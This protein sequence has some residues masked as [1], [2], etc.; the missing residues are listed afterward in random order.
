MVNNE[1]FSTHTK[2][3]VDECKE[4]YKHITTTIHQK[5]K[6]TYHLKPSCLD[7]ILQFPKSDMEDN[8]DYKSM[9]TFLSWHTEEDYQEALMDLSPKEVKDI[10]NL[11]KNASMMIFSAKQ[12]V[13]SIAKQ[14]SE[15]MDMEVNGGRTPDD[16]RNIQKGRIE[17]MEEALKTITDEREASIMMKYINDIGQT[18]NFSFMTSRLESLEDKEIKNI[19]AGFF[20]EKKGK[21]IIEKFAKKLPKCGF[22]A[23]IYQFFFNIEEMFLDEK[24]HPYNN[25]FLY[26]YMR[27]VAYMNTNSKSDVL[28]VQS[29]TSAM[30]QLIYHKFPNSENE[31]A[32]ISIVKKTLAYFKP[33]VDEFKKHNS[34]YPKHELRRQSEIQH[35]LERLNSV[36]DGRKTLGMD[37]DKEKVTAVK[38]D[39][40]SESSLKW[41]DEYESAFRD[42][43]RELINKQTEEYNNTK[44]KI[45]KEDVDNELPIQSIKDLDK[46]VTKTLSLTK[47]ARV[48][49]KNVKSLDE[50][51]KEHKE[52]ETGD[53]DKAKDKK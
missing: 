14:A 8:F 37:V 13:D 15:I 44:D 34:T 11:V 42:Y 6:D 49:L 36:I 50:A 41:I 10:V 4:Y 7:G 9:L 25:L 51:E 33:Y 52:K 35:Q 26:M 31:K 16:L 12:E 1:K 5:L 28:Y 19:M 38:D 45:V 40:L 24:Y 46:S 3:M 20:D 32:F 21:Y 17:K 39:I 53:D 48:A 43:A 27:Y 47:E 2:T 23:N 22:N 18:L 29:I 30:S